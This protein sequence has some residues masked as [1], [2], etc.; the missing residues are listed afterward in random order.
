MATKVGVLHKQSKKLVLNLIDYFIKER[1]N[2]GP[3]IPLQQVH[4]RV[5]EA[6]NISLR[7][8]CRIKH[9]NNVLTKKR[10]RIRKKPKTLDVCDGVKM[11]IREVI[12]N[13]YES[14]THFID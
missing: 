5:S 6:L 8:I 3:L 2:E 1:E 11:E 10:K 13:F 14:K 12:Y 9:H 7:T 4:E